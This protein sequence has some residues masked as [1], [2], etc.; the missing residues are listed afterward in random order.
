[1]YAIKRDRSWR[2][3]SWDAPEASGFPRRFSTGAINK[4]GD[5]GDEAEHLRNPIISTAFREIVLGFQSSLRLLVLRP[6]II[7][8]SGDTHSSRI[9]GLRYGLALSRR[10]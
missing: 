1:M 8:Y 9:S 3:G 5:V 10:A 2:L 7:Y 6:I 4:D